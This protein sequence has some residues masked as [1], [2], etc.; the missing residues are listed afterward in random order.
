MGHLCSSELREAHLVCLPTSLNPP[1]LTSLTLPP[2]VK[3]HPNKLLCFLK[4]IL[5]P[6]KLLHCLKPVCCS[7]FSA[8]NT[9]N[10]HLR[11]LGKQRSPSLAFIS[12]SKLKTQQRKNTNCGPSAL[13]KDP[14][15]R[16]E[17]QEDFG[18]SPA[19]CA[20]P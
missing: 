19:S 11:P 18:F 10:S 3:L 16:G 15:K 4:A 13:Q 17:E 1:S 7:Y 20:A 5:H 9:P 8:R 12:A 6:S 14:K 2:V